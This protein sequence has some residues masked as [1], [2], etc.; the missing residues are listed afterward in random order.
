M[1]YKKKSHK[2]M[3]RS[4]KITEQTD[5]ELET[6]KLLT[7]KKLKLKLTKGELV[8]YA[9]KAYQQK[10][11]GKKMKINTYTGYTT[12]KRY[13]VLIQPVEVDEGKVFHCF[14]DLKDL[15]AVIDSYIKDL[16]EEED[17]Q[18]FVKLDQVSK[19]GNSNLDVRVTVTFEQTMNLF[20]VPEPVNIYTEDGRYSIEAVEE[21][22]FLIGFTAVLTLEEYPTKIL[23]VMDGLIDKKGITTDLMPIYILLIVHDRELDLF[24]A[25]PLSIIINFYPDEESQSLDHGQ[26]MRVLQFNDFINKLSRGEVLLEEK[27]SRKRW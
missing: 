1:I 26:E 23:E 5:L 8:K 6:L 21:Y 16:S 3:M 14:T 7:M 9:L 2:N 20:Y 19:N 27:I 17:F 11:M 25:F 24:E 18:I 4:L 15:R 13:R 10:L 22:D 12:T